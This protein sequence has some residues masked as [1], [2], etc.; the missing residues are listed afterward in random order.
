[1]TEKNKQIIQLDIPVPEAA[2]MMTRAAQAGVSFSHY[3]QVHALQGVYG[4]LHPTVV[5]FRN[6]L[7]A[8]I[9]GPLT[10]DEG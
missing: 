6:R 1:M 8:G 9:C 5:E 2:D 7:K 3:I 10:Q 4:V